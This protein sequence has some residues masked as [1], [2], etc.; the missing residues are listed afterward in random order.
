MNV[1][2]ESIYFAP[3]TFTPNGDGVNDVFKP[4]FALGFIP[5]DYLLSIYDH[6]GH[7]IF[8]TKDY[9]ASWD[10]SNCMN[11]HYI[12]QM[13]FISLVEQDENIVQGTIELL[14]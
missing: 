1:K 12:W 2:K 10:G 5:I 3:N 11:G 13:K 14:K 4:I 7:V 9:K 6:W 8:S